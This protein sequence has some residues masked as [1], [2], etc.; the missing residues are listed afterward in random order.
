L[1]FWTE[2]LIQNRKRDLRNQQKLRS[3][4]WRILIVWECQLK[5]AML[6]ARLLR[7]LES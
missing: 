1:E 5:R 2:K 4:G 6:P 7:F 3:S